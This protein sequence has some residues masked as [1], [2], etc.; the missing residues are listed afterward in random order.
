MKVVSAGSKAGLT[1]IGRSRVGVLPSD[2]FFCWSVGVVPPPLLLGL[3][4]S[5][6]PGGTSDRGCWWRRKTGKSHASVICSLPR[7]ATSMLQKI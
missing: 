1:R 4:G 2:V 6:D 3:N 7:S 5:R